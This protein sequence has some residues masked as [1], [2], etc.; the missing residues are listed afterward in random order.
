MQPRPLRL[1]DFPP[2][3]QSFIEQAIK[4]RLTPAEKEELARAEGR[5]PDLARTIRRLAEKYPVLPPLPSGKIMYG[6]QLFPRV[7]REGLRAVAY[8]KEKGDKKGKQLRPALA[9]LN[10]KWP[11]FALAAAAMIKQKGVKPPALGASKPAEFPEEMRPALRQ[12]LAALSDEQRKSLHA[13][14]GRWPEYPQ[15][16]HE[17]AWQKEVHI[18]GMTLPGPR[19]LWEDALAA[20]PDV[21]GRLLLDFALNEL[22]EEERAGLDLSAADPKGSRERLKKAYYHFKRRKSDRTALGEVP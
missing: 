2:G 21:P 11:E 7:S 17:L 10:G 13:L 1:S 6:I 18:P 3:V 15:R 20:L 5:W 12:L 8:S 14:E 9:K 22:T 16:V 19:K 4:P